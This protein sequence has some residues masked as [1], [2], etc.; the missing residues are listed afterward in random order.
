M[1]GTARPTGC[2][3]ALGYERSQK[4]LPHLRSNADYA[5]EWV[6]RSI[7]LLETSWKLSGLDRVGAPLRLRNDLLDVV[8]EIWVRPGTGPAIMTVFSHL[9]SGRYA[10]PIQDVADVEAALTTTQTARDNR[11]PFLVR[12]MASSDRPDQIRCFILF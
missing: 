3:L 5:P 12:G 9:G 8:S 11:V 1:H 2:G 10:L 6:N 7:R 4:R